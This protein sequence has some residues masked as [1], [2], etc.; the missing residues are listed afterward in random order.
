[1]EHFRDREKDYVQQK[2]HVYSR[3]LIDLCVKHRAGSL[4][5]VGQAE[6]EAA[7]VGE[8]FVLR[9]WSYYALKE[10]IQYKAN[11]AGILLITE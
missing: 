1:M 3:Q 10:K 4:I 9:N 6:K 5:L 7:A 11:K 8:E 2:L